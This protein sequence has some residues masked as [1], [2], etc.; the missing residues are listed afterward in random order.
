[1][2]D[3]VASAT[4]LGAILASFFG[5]LKLLNRIEK[6]LWLKFTDDFKVIMESHI[7]DP[8]S[9]FLE[10]TTESLR[11]S[12]TIFFG[13]KINLRFFIT[14]I[15]FSLST[16]WI[17]II[18]W[19]IFNPSEFE[20]FLKGEILSSIIAI[21]IAAIFLNLIPDIASLT[22]TSF[23]V[24]KLEFLYKGDNRTKN[25]F[26]KMAQYI[27]LDVAFSLMISVFVIY[28]YSIVHIMSFEELLLKAI[29]MECTGRNSYTPGI[30]FY[31]TFSTSIWVLIWSVA[32]FFLLPNIIW[33]GF[34]KYYLKIFRIESPLEP[35]FNIAKGLAFIILIAFCLINGFEIRDIIKELI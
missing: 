29:K 26:F 23:I 28:L 15:C 18:L 32:N 27:I 4:T 21:F 11:C 5:V 6:K 2:I 30:F 12:F 14:S 7:K 24:K 20:N 17:V 8:R 31:T 25:P 19:S 3:S 16:V 9:K 10:T 1:M 33:G 34:V 22:E 13:N 35:I